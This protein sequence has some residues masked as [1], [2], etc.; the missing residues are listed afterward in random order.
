MFRTLSAHLATPAEAPPCSSVRYL[1]MKGATGELRTATFRTREHIVVPVV[2]LVQGVVHAVNADK[3][4]LVRI[5]AVARSFQSWNGRP[6]MGGHPA[7]SDGQPVMANDPRVLE[8]DSFGMVFNA[9]IQ[10]D[11]LLVEAWIDPALVRTGTVAENVLR[12]L[13]DGQTIE[14]SI[15]AFIIAEPKE[16]TFGGQRYYSEWKEIFPDHL[17]MLHETETGACSVEMGCGALRDAKVHLVTAKGIEVQKET[18][19]NKCSKCEKELAEGATCDCASKPEPLTLKQRVLNLFKFRT[20]ATEDLTVSDLTSELDRA[21]R[22]IEPGYQGVLDVLINQNKV[23]Y[24]VAP[25]D[26]WKILQRSYTVGENGKIDIADDAEEVRMVNRY[27]PVAE[28]RAAQQ[29]VACGCHNKT[30]PAQSGEAEMN[31]AERIAALIAAGTYKDSDKPWLEAMPEA[32]IETLAT[33]QEKAAAGQPVSA[34]V[35]TPPSAAG[36]VRTAQQFFDTIGDPQLKES[37][38]E[39]HRHLQERRSA[40]ITSLKATGRCN[41][42]EAELGAMSTQSLQNLASLASVPTPAASLIANFAARGVPAEQVNEEVIEQPPSLIAALQ[43][44][45]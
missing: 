5:E 8:R 3:P 15:G 10:D 18:I 32:A 43:A 45:K 35:S 26:A 9:D 44:R 34:P 25:E 23:V 36:E 33:T 31:K 29:R 27:E 2:A 20:A 40:I 39:S 28:S 19:M 12:R 13:Q 4:E 37:M 41:Y 14:V 22:A 16:G 30:A 7:D 1:T 11:R 42:T 6:V 24:V 38:M 17:A 21:I